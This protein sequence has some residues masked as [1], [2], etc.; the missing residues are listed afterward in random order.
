MS[1][2]HLVADDEL[3][4][5]AINQVVLSMGL[6]VSPERK[7]AIALAVTGAGYTAAQVKL[8]AQALCLDVDLD[9]KLRYGYTLTAADFRR[10]IEGE[11]GE[12]AKARLYTYRE[13]CAFHG[14]QGEGAVWPF[15]PVEVERRDGDGPSPK[16][17]WRLA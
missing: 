16:P 13:A 14:R 1:E 3:V 11:A 6:D 17:M 12:V 5:Q 2:F 8:A 15:E 9:A 10:V 4:M 7:A